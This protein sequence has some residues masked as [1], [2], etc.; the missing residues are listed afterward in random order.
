MQC[1]VHFMHFHLQWVHSMTFSGQMHCSGQQRNLGK[2]RGSYG[3]C[4]QDY[5]QQTVHGAAQLCMVLR[6][7]CKALSIRISP[8]GP[9]SFWCAAQPERRMF[10]NHPGTQ[11]SRSVSF[12]SLFFFS[13]LF[14][15]GYK[16]LCQK[17]LLPSAF[18]FGYI[19][20]SGWWG[21]KL[22]LNNIGCNPCSFPELAVDTIP[23]GWGCQGQAVQFALQTEEE[24]PEQLLALLKDAVWGAIGLGRDVSPGM[25]AWERDLGSSHFLL[26]FLIW[27]LFCVCK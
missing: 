2:G 19:S 13:M 6:A 17:S 21:P 10:K 4:L 24:C 9:G 5:F 27:R 22:V 11:H 16:E 7:V 26:Y 1:Q 14:P 18:F 3:S 20:Q 12:C 8:A 15:P 23:R 25:G